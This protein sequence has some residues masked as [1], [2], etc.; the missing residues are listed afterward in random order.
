MLSASLLLATAAVTVAA[1]AP[2]AGAETPPV[3]QSHGFFL[4][5]SA[6]GVD[7]AT[8]ATLDDARAVNTGGPAVT[9][10]NPLGAT[11]LGQLSIPVGQQTIPIGSGLTFGVLN[12]FAQASPD[13]S[14]SASSGAVAHNGAVQTA[15]DAG[16]AGNM[17]LDLQAL[18]AGSG[19]PAGQ[20][21]ALGNAT[22]TAGALAG[23][24][25]RGSFG[26][27]GSLG[28]AGG[29]YQIGSLT[30]DV[31]AGTALT[32]L[33]D[34]LTGAATDVRDAVQGALD[35]ATA[36]LPLNGVLT[37]SGDLPD[38]D[39]LLASVT[40]VSGPG[41]EAD[42]LAGTLSLDLVQLIESATGEDINALDP[43]TELLPLIVGALPNGDRPGDR[44]P[45]RD[46]ARHRP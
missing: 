6:G 26:A 22:L 38:P 36:A 5:G 42:L 24:A 21:A 34:T 25:T 29:S 9:T 23:R 37:V 28:A 13:G 27:D 33:L 11:V 39:A 19:L 31:T 45:A 15:A 35:D 16:T 40:S 7:L 44:H 10:A 46:A 8:V 30:L 1:T 18:A 12:Q 20:L 32:D 41:Y 3:S 17:S 14:A 43:N 4:A 2:P